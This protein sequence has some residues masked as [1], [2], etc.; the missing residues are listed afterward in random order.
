MPWMNPQNM[1]LCFCTTV[2]FQLFLKLL[3]LKNHSWVELN[4]QNRARWPPFSRSP[5]LFTVSSEG[6]V[7]KFCSW[8][9]CNLSL[10]LK[11][12]IKLLKA[13]HVHK[14]SRLPSLAIIIITAC[15]LSSHMPSRHHIFT[16]LFFFACS[17]VQTF[18]SCIHLCMFFWYFG[19]THSSIFFL[20]RM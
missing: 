10:S 9:R 12:Q 18:N 1:T 19:W 13:L 5:A 2:T 17:S 14:T 11:Q 7:V 16:V 3:V 8:Q 15:S 6:L 20:W 4:V